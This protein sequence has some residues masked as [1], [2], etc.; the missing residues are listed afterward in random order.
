MNIRKPVDYSEL[1][2][3]LDALMVRELPQM[4]LYLEI[5]RVIC[6]RSEKGAAV[7]AAEYLKERYP[8]CSGFSPRNVRRMRDFYQTY[9]GEPELM[10]K[11]LGIGWTLNVLILEGDLSNADREWYILM[12]RQSGWSKLELAAQIQQSAHTR[13]SEKRVLDTAA[14]VCYDEQEDAAVRASEDDGKI[15]DSAEP[16]AADTAAAGVN[17]PD[18]QVMPQMSPV[19]LPELRSVNHLLNHQDRFGACAALTRNPSE[20]STPGASHLQRKV[21]DNDEKTAVGDRYAKRLH[22]RLPGDERGGGHRRCCQGENPLL[23]VAGYYSHDGHTRENLSGHTGGAESSSGTLRPWHRRLAYS[24]GH[25]LPS[26]RSDNLRKTYLRKCA[27]GGG[28]ERFVADRGYRTGTCWPL[29]GHLCNFQCPASESYDA[30]GSDFRRRLLLR[31]GHAGE[32]Y[33]SAGNYE[34]LSDTCDLKQHQP[35]RSNAQRLSY[36]HCRNSNRR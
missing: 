24:S 3:A 26:D 7:H 25:C 22:R 10:N 23:P 11:A 2:Q 18:E 32:A 30:G 16:E 20:V 31:R 6:V 5:G 12:A 34:I 28:F 17:A 19:V 13:D 15:M 1:H 35:L 33:C 8:D 36:S 21:G 14:Q 27:T 29:H 4:A 9:Q